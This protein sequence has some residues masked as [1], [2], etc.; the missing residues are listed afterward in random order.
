MHSFKQKQ[1]L[2]IGL[3]KQCKSILEKFSQAIVEVKQHNEQNQNINKCKDCFLRI[4][5]KIT[6]GW[7]QPWLGDIDKHDAIWKW[8]TKSGGT[9]QKTCFTW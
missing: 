7:M 5:K 2:S 9:R 4:C 3:F 6:N 1:T 8:I